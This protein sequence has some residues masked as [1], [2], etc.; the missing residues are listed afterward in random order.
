MAITS[1]AAPTDIFKQE[2]PKAV[3]G[4][5]NN[6]FGQDAFLKLLVTQLRFQDP[7]EPVDNEEFLG[8]MAQ[9]TG[10]EQMAKLNKTL[11]KLAGSS[12]KTEVVSLLGTNVTVIP[13]GQVLNEG[14]TPAQVEGIVDQI[15]FDGPIPMLR[16]NGKEYSFEDVVKVG[17]PQV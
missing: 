3:D 8:Q 11:E 15:K 12:L 2:S 9:F 5:N 16:V 1:L 6:A 13:S 14:Q 10:V 17:V 7:S 4:T